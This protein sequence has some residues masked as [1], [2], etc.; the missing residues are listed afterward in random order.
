MV[1]GVFIHTPSKR[2]R[3]TLFFWA[4]PRDVFFERKRAEGGG[5]LNLNWSLVVHLFKIAF[6][7]EDELAT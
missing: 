7:E 5:G 4:H 6:L 2:R 3:E 1:E